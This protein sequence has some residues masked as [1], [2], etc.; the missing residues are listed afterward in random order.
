MNLPED[1]SPTA[2]TQI[3]HNETQNPRSNAATIKH[4]NH[5]NKITAFIKKFT[6]PSMTKNKK[7]KSI[8][9]LVMLTKKKLR[10]SITITNTKDK[11]S[12]VC[13]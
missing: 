11:M 2:A 12:W 7:Q 8:S 13:G 6:A 1:L 10:V 3:L 5:T 9:D 4:N